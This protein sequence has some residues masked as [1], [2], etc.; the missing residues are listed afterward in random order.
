MTTQD[1]TLIREI[2]NKAK[3]ANIGKLALDFADEIDKLKLEKADKNDERVREIK[4]E[5]NSCFGKW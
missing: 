5:F 3:D 1:I 2:I 4:D